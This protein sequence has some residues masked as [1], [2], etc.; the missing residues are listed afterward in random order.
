[1]RSK[2]TRKTTVG[3]QWDQMTAADLAAATQGLEKV[4]FEDTRPMTAAQRRDWERS[5]HGPGRPR[6]AAGEKAAR[7][8]VTLKPQ[9]LAEA[10]AYA[11]EEGISRAELFARGLKA[12]LPVKGRRRQGV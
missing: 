3:K 9:L 4:R 5:R 1:M 12:V 10:D 2:K 6:K 8:L 11:A 7:V